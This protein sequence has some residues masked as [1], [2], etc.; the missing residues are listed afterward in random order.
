M[1]FFSLLLFKYY[2]VSKANRA[3]DTPCLKKKAEDKYG[4]KSFTD[5]KNENTFRY[6]I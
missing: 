2:F 5:F 6:K 4:K 1:I 3:R